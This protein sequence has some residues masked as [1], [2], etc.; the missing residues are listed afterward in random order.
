MP[1]L[2][3]KTAIVTGSSRGIGAALARALAAAG[4]RV[5]VN[6]A[7]REDAAQS[8]VKEIESKGGEAIAVQAD[9]SK[10]A[11]ARALF[12]RSEDRFG[13]VDILVNNAG[14]IVYKMLVDTTDDDFDRIMSINVRGV[15]NLLREA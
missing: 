4:A 6:Y 8:V 10:V 9:I 15:F 2:S 5:V 12:S 14:V 13:K 11:D 7:G 1:D 3:H